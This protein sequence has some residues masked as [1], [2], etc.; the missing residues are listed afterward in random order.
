MMMVMIVMGIMMMMVV[1]MVFM[2]WGG[3]DLYHVAVLLDNNVRAIDH[4][5]TVLGLACLWRQ[6]HRNSCGLCLTTSLHGSLLRH[7]LFLV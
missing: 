6:A 2:F 1:V 7:I 4:W 5:N 3:V